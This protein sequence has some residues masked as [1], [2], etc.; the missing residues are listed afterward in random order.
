MHEYPFLV[1]DNPAVEL[2]G[3]TL[4]RHRTYPADG[5]FRGRPLGDNPLS[6]SEET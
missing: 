1:A 6:A 3:P 4:S 2:L 5:Y